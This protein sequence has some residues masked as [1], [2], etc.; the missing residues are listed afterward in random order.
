MKIE[1]PFF[2]IVH[3]APVYFYGIC[4]KLWF[5][6]QRG[7]LM[8]YPWRR[9]FLLIVVLPSEKNLRDRTSAAKT[10]DDVF[11]QILL[12]VPWLLKYQLQ[13]QIRLQ[14]ILKCLTLK[15]A[16][17]QKRLYTFTL[18]VRCDDAILHLKNWKLAWSKPYTTLSIS[19]KKRMQQNFKYSTN[20]KSGIVDMMIRAL[21]T[22]PI[23]ELLATL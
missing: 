1:L 18:S 20:E 3:K 16:P 5:N 13:T 21:L 7:L 4:Q 19:G 10:A 17:W 11:C 6:G 14:R 15:T 12:F 2:V 8:G 22:T 23:L 9:C